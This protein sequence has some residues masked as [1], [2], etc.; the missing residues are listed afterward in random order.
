S[1][2][3]IEKEAYAQVATLE[4]IDEDLPDH[5]EEEEPIRLAPAS[6][7]DTP[8]KFRDPTEKLNLGTKTEPMEV[9]ISANL[10]PEEK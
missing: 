5:E 6:L 10:E 7:D 2:Y 9:A 1:S 4:Y 3:L 8:P